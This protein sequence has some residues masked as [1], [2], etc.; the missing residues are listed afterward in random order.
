MVL[1]LA[2]SHAQKVVKKC[3]K[4]GPKMAPQPDLGAKNCPKSCKKVLKKLSKS[5]FLE[6]RAPKR[7]A[8]AE[9]RRAPFWVAA[10]GRHL[11]FP[12][13]NFLIIFRPLFYNFLGSFLH[14]DLAG[15]IFGPL[16]GHFLT[17]FWACHLAGPKTIPGQLFDH[18]C[19]WAL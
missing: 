15:A 1:G 4:S 11:Y 14:P 18:F 9:G 6:N 13:N 16:F 3:P 8:A 19:F 12:K 7:G 2:K 5:C 17:T 10:E